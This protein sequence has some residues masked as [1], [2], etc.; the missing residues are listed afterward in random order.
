MD[1]PKPGPPLHN[2]SRKKKPVETGALKPDGKLIL[3]S[4]SGIQHTFT[5]E[6]M[7]K[8]WRVYNRYLSISTKTGWSNW[9]W[10]SVLTWETVGNSE[11]YRAARTAKP[12][13]E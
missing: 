1:I 12:E 8:G 4:T 10:S 9:P 13:Q 7:V 2:D 5:Y 11:T 6:E 3:I